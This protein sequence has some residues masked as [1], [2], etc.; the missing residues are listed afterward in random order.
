MDGAAQRFAC[1]TTPP[2]QQQL[3]L[4]EAVFSHA[5]VKVDLASLEH[6]LFSLSRKPVKTVR[7]YALGRDCEIT[8][9]PSASGAPTLEDKDILVY[10]TSQI[11]AALNAG[12]RVS[13]VVQIH[14]Y[15]LLRTIGRQVGGRDYRRLTSALTRLRGTTIETRIKTGGLRQENGF[16]LID[17]WQLLEQPS[18]HAPRLQIRLGD[19]LF[20]AI[21]AGEVLTV[22]DSY[23]Q[24]E[25]LEKR[26]Y[27]ILRKHLSDQPAWKIDL[28][29]LRQ[30]CGSQS[31]L[32]RF[33]FE[34][35]KILDRATRRRAGGADSPFAVWLLSIHGK[36]LVGYANTDAGR[37]LRAADALRA[38]RSS[39]PVTGGATELQL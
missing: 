20:R 5:S 27:E 6:P 29:R 23:F 24:L 35:R 2:D 3:E 13:P 26:L 28:G 22:D 31:P 12:L 21:L 25:G 39:M 37:A 32:R 14:G 10:V 4:F 36:L 34:L 15:D 16:G 33:R 19:W 9:I 8:I 38:I 30:K 11:R 7:H 17:A 18:I 1:E